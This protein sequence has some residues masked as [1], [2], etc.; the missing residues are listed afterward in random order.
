MLDAGDVEP[1]EVLEYLPSGVSATFEDREDVSAAQRRHIREL[2]LSYRGRQAW[3]SVRVHEPGYAPGEPD[4]DALSFLCLALYVTM[5]AAERMRE[6]PDFLSRGDSMLVLSPG[7]NG[8]WAESTHQPRGKPPAVPAPFD[9]AAIVRQAGIQVAEPSGT[10]DI[11]F[12]YLPGFVSAGRGERAYNP[13]VA[14]V[15]DATSKLI[16]KTFMEA[17]DSFLRQAQIELFNLLVRARPAIIRVRHA[18]AVA[19]LRS[20]AR[21]FGCRLVTA[22]SVPAADHVRRELIQQMEAML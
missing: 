17:P 19:M 7:A 8:R 16:L 13:R 12:F 21:A 3:P 15:V 20:M 5:Y 18:D 10:W 22:D 6:Q 9:Y 14:I 1:S 2:G 11:D 4:D